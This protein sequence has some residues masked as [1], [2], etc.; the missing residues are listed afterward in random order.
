MYNATTFSVYHPNLNRDAP[1]GMSSSQYSCAFHCKTCAGLLLHT[2]SFPCCTS[3]GLAVYAT[4]FSSALLSFLSSFVLF[5]RG[6]SLHLCPF[7]PYLKHSTAITSCLLIIFSS[8]SHCI[9]LLFNTSNLF[10]GM[11]VPFSPSFLFL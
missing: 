8:A 10:W 7:S 11:T 6:H 4:S 5:Y 3:R 9:T 1:S 2:S